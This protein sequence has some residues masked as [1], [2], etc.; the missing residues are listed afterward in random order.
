MVYARPVRPDLVL[1]ENRIRL[2]TCGSSRRQVA[3]VYAALELAG[4]PDGLPLAL[5]QA[6]AFTRATG[7][8]IADYLATFRERRTDPLA[9]GE[10]TGYGKRLATTWTLAFD[11]LQ[12]SAPLCGN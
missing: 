12:Q 4:E 10:P 9:R 1:L 11:L 2:V 6:A 7:R 3:R 8:S 5:E